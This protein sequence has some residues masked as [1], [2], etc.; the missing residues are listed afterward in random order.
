[1]RL[2]VICGSRNI[3]R[4]PFGRAFFALRLTAVLLGSH[5][6]QKMHDLLSILNGGKT[7]V[8][9]HFIPRNDLI[10]IGYE[11]RKSCFI[12]DEIAVPHR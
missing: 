5:R 4:P 8:G 11:A 9:S 10:W 12:P 1:M 6:L 2:Q 7:P 3:L